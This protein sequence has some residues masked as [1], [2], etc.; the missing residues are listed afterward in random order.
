MDLLG[1]D[2]PIIPNAQPYFGALSPSSTSNNNSPQLGMGGI[3]LDLFSTPVQ[4]S[5]QFRSPIPDADIF[6]AVP[7]QSVK[8]SIDPFSTRQMKSEI[9]AVPLGRIPPK[10]IWLTAQNGRGLEISG[11]CMN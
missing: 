7:A 9:S 3:P 2:E 6:S 4:T 1:M 8:P 10:Q 11:T 5:P